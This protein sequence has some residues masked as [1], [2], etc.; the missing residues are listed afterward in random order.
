[1]EGDEE[2]YRFMV[3]LKTRL[4]QKYE[5]LLPMPGG[6]H[7]M[8]HA[9]KAL[10]QRYYAAGIE[11]ICSECDADDKH[12]LRGT[13]YRR[14]HHWLMVTFEALWCC[15]IE[16]YLDAHPQVHLGENDVRA[17]VIPWLEA[18]AKRHETFRF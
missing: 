17:N 15:V 16:R 5:W 6:W 7:I 9:S 13:N 10:L 3:N 2:T 1:M 14:N 8:L 4:P 11:S 12:V 18:R